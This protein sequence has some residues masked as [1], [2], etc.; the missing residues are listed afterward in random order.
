MEIHKVGVDF[1]S[2]LVC[3]KY[4]NA[5]NHVGLKS[6]KAEKAYGP[7]LRPCSFRVRSFTT[8]T[9]RDR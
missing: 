9:R 3:H 4:Q 2:P 5:V 8:L 6:G 7:I 1:L